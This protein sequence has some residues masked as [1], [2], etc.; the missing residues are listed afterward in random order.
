[1][2]KGEKAKSINKPPELFVHVYSLNSKLSEEK[3]KSDKLS[4]ELDAHEESSK[5][6]FAE[7]ENERSNVTKLQN[8]LRDAKLDQDALGEQ[9]KR[10]QSELEQQH[11]QVRGQYL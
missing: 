10:K 4:A 1:M 11:A 5:I 9:L 2:L 3:G 7:L 6:A 8:K